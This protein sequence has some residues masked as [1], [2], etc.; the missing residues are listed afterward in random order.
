V[1]NLIGAM[2]VLFF[3]WLDLSGDKFIFIKV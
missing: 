2:V 3:L 1:R